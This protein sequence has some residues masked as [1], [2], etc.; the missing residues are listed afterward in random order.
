MPAVCAPSVS[1]PTCTSGNTLRTV[2][3]H[4]T[5]HQVS[6]L[7]VRAEPRLVAAITE[8]EPVRAIADG[9]NPAKTTVRGYAI[10]SC[11]HAGRRT[12]VPGR[13][14]RRNQRSQPLATATPADHEAEHLPKH[15]SAAPRVDAS[16]NP[17]TSL[18]GRL[19]F[20]ARTLPTPGNRGVL[21]RPTPDIGIPNEQRQGR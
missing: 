21:I 11:R 7:P 16:T 20:S 12:S 3:E 4:M 15:S 5:N 10:P 13:R 2:A 8:R 6:K 1:T 19:A 14:M 18:S 9:A 17:T